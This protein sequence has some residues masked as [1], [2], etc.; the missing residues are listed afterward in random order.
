MKM[1]IFIAYF[2]G[3]RREECSFVGVWCSIC[4]VLN[5]STVGRV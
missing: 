2:N 5:Q 1:D 3:F 4:R